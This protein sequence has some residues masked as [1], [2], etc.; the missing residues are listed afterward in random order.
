MA[1]SKKQ[2]LQR[3]INQLTDI[4]ELLDEINQ[5]LEMVSAGDS[6]EEPVNP[7]LDMANHLAVVAKGIGNGRDRKVVESAVRALKQAPTGQQ[8]HPS[9]LKHCAAALG[10]YSSIMARVKDFLKEKAADK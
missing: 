8:I 9:T 6:D 7:N 1:M 3:D 2:T 4:N 5:E 10:E